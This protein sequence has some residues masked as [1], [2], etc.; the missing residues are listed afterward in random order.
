MCLK[1][2]SALLF[3]TC[4]FIFFFFF[5]VPMESE[6]PEQGIKPGPQQKPRPL[7]WQCW[8][9]NLFYH[10]ELKNISSLTTD[11]FFIVIMDWS[12]QFLGFLI[13]PSLSEYSSSF[14]FCFF[15]IR[16]HTYFFFIHNHSFLTMENGVLIFSS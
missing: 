5:P 10:W 7:Q 4:A 3:A 15:L 6:V 9:R 1:C 2:S 12:T 16:D 13:L 14:Q 8:I 11:K